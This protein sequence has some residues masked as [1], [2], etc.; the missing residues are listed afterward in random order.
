MVNPPGRVPA[1]TGDPA[2]AAL[3]VTGAVDAGPVARPVALPVAV[4]LTVLTVVV[5]GTVSCAWSCR[6]AEAAFTVPR[7]HVEVP[8]P[9]P[10]PRLNCAVPVPAGLTCSAIAAFATFPPVAQ[11]ATDHW[12]GLAGRAALLQGGDLD[13][14]VDRHRRRLGG[15]V[16]GPGACGAAACPRAATTSAARTAG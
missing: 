11:A 14:Q 10:Q 3:M 5:S 7:V 13:A 8:L 1:P 9:D 16:A 15:T 6:W 4:R 12:A 2:A